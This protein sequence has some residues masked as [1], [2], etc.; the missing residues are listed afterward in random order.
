[1]TAVLAK[2]EK[3]AEGPSLPDMTARLAALG[4]L[5]LPALRSE[6]QRSNRAPAPACFSRDLLLRSLAYR[7]QERSIG[8]L[9]ASSRRRLA[10]AGPPDTAG[11]APPAPIRLKPGSTLVREWHGTTHTVLVTEGGF[12]FQ[13]RRY[14]SL[15]QIAREITGAHWSGP[16][17]FGL[18]RGAE[19]QRRPAARKGGADAAPS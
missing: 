4:Q 3:G 10:N 13:R 9:P 5:D 18:K 19:R 16:R 12:D 8:G 17:F 2:V 14:P 15:S 7:L 6:W 11:R 1:M